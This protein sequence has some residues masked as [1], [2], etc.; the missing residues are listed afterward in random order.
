MGGALD[1]V[2]LNRDRGLWR[3]LTSS[4]SV[5][6][7]DT[8][9]RTPRLFRARGRGRTWQ[10]PFDDQWLGLCLVESGP[11]VVDGDRELDPSEVDAGDVLPWALRVGSRHEYTWRVS[12]VL[13][14]DEHYVIQRVVE[15]IETLDEMPPENER[16]RTPDEVDFLDG[17]EP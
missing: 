17:P 10:S 15:R 12:G 3:V 9:S 13:G 7:V 6:Y 1:Y 14:L 11:R 4:S 8:R 2:D 5:Y 16:T